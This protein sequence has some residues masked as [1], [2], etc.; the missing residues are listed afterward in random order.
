MTRPKH[1][2]AIAL[3]NNAND[4][5]WSF[6]MRELQGTLRSPIYWLIT[7]SAIVLTAMAGPYFTLER[8]S[9][10]ER[11]VY[12]GITVLCSALVMT[13]LS[14]IAYRVAEAKGWT[15][16]LASLSASLIGVVPV[17]ASVY[18]AEGLVAGFGEEP[19]PLKSLLLSVAPAL[20]GVTMVVHVFLKLQGE[21]H[22]PEQ[23]KP[24]HSPA[25][26][27]TQLQRKLPPHLGHDIVSVRAQDHYVEVTTSQGSAMVLMRLGDAVAD[28][29]PLRGLRVHRSW[30]IRLAHVTRT[31]QGSN[32]PEVLMSTG[33]RIP[34]GRSFRAA[35]RDAT[36]EKR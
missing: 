16:V 22:P 36:A 23:S 15:W 5:T 19:V 21:Q 10:A 31:E 30:W 24:A 29:E 18:L 4:T 35:F 17:V 26:S 13:F 34:V 12:W 33:Q 28:L 3:K 32:G 11:L 27:L 7:G 20:V 8:L 6:A 25:L 14:I 1:N 2:D 9:F